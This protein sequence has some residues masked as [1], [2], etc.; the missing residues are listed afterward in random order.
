MNEDINQ[1]VISRKRPRSTSLS[2]VSSV[3][4]I[5]TDASNTKGENHSPTVHRSNPQRTRSRSSSD[6]QSRSQS[7]RSDEEVD[8]R[9]RENRRVDHARSPAHHRPK[10]GQQTPDSDEVEPS[11]RRR[12]QRRD[13]HEAENSDDRHKSERRS[14]RRRSQSADIVPDPRRLNSSSNSTRQRSLSPY[15]R[16]L[17][18]TQ[19]MNSGSR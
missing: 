8:E 18:L 17:A 5:S 6:R 2:S 16:R 1:N 15:S 10:K 9:Q 7:N 14:K 11:V 19:A 13:R 3:A 4:T 12:L